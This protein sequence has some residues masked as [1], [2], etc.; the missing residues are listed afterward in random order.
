MQEVQLFIADTRVDLFKD[1]NINLTQT[2]QNVKDIGSIFTDFS[3]SFTIPASKTNNKIFRHYYNFE[4][5]NGFN[6]NDKVE[7]EIKL[8]TYL[9]RKGYIA[10]DGVNMKDN[11]PSAYKLTFFG[12]TVDLKKKLKEITLQNIFEGIN[13]YNHDYNLTNVRQGLRGQLFA[14]A[15]IYP[16]ISHTERFYYDSSQTSANSRNLYFSSGTNQGVNF[17][18]LKPALRVDEIIEQI[19]TYAV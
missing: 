12:E 8:N 4:I 10:L 11:K 17:R 9:F 18:D 5:I 15:I 6:A 19:E 3:Q 2:I 16:L 14:G 1:E 13:T 7:A